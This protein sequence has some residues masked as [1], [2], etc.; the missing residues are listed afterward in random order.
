M[1]DIATEINNATLYQQ[2]LLSVFV[3]GAVAAVAYL[4]GRLFDQTDYASRIRR[5]P[6]ILCGVRRH[7]TA[8][9]LREHPNGHDA[10]EKWRIPVCRTC[11]RL[12]EAAGANQETSFFEARGIDSHELASDLYSARKD[13]ARMR[14]FFREHFTVI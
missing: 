9:R 5:L 14:A 8:H 7:I 1:S 13:P 4:V 11:L 12:L 2:M 10:I 6:C 3:V